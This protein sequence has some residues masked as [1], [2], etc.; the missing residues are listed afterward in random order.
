MPARETVGFRDRP[1]KGCGA[2]AMEREFQG[3]VKHKCT[4]Q[5]NKQPNGSA[6]PAEVG[7]QGKRNSGTDDQPGRA[8]ERN[9][10]HEPGEL[11]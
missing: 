8:H 9:R 4:Y 2:C 7:E 1:E 11:R 6:P 10:K 5:R 3:Q